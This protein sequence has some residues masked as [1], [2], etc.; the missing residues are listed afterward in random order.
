[1]GYNGISFESNKLIL[2]HADSFFYTPNSW[3][4]D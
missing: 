1:M 2:G 3:Q 4:L